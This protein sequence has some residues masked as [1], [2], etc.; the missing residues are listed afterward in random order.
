M[1]MTNQEAYEFVISC[2][3]R[4]QAYTKLAESLMEEILK[5]CNEG[6]PKEEILI[7]AIRCIGAGTGNAVF[8]KQCLEKLR[9]NE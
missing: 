4:E 8:A 3:G 5:D 2:W 7:K 6:K 1:H 9:G